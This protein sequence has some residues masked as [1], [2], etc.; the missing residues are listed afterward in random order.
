MEHEAIIRAVVGSACFRAESECL[1]RGGW[2]VVE[3]PR[4]FKLLENEKAR[5]IFPTR[6]VRIEDGVAVGLVCLF[7]VS[8]GV[9]QYAHAVFAGASVNASLRSLFVPPKQSKPQPGVAGEKAILQFVAWKAAAWTKFLNDEL[10]LGND[11]ASGVWISNFWKA[12]DRMY[13]GSN[14]RAEASS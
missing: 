1:N 8:S 6:C 12:L 3:R 7:D 2:P 14:L 13:G 5:L 11:G 9:N 10:E 4:L